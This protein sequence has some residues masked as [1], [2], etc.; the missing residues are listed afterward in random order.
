M[1]L[2]K[3]KRR[4]GRARNSVKRIVA[5]AINKNIETKQ[6]TTSS[7][8]G[9]EILHNNFVTLD[10]TV[11]KTTQGLQDD[12]ALGQFANRIGDKIA[13]KG[14][15]F[16]MMLELNERYSD[17]TF[18]IML[19]KASRGD[20][21]TRATLF[22]QWSGNKMLDQINTER[23]TVLR[24]KYV[25]MLAPGMT[26]S[27]T[28]W[29]TTTSGIYEGG[30]QLTSRATRIVKFWVPGRKFVRSG[31]VKYD[32]GGETPKFF[33]FHLIVYAYSNYG[34]AQDVWNVGRVNDY[35]KHMYYKDG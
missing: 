22:R 12:T 17:V 6:S 9:V 26:A 19:I 23:Y 5:R 7:T 16:K 15:Q 32:S 18:R 35:V 30:V 31:I 4:T 8:D 29:G 10:S 34:T 2:Y 27:G 33:D 20:T 13:L 14:V 1:G 21:P 11:L 3:R 24:T 25:K 28:S